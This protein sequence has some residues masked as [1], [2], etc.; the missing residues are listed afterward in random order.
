LE[1]TKHGTLFIDEIGE[2]PL[3]SQVK[4]L[5]LLEDRTYCKLG[6]TEVL[7]FKGRIIMA[8]H[9]NLKKMMKKKLFREDLFYRV[10]ILPLSIPPLRKRKEEL[11]L[12]SNKI[13]QKIGSSKSLTYNALLKLYNY[14]WPGNIREL[15]SVLLRANTMSNSERWIESAD[16]FFY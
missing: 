15:Q 7:H 4:L 16:I 13:L 5:R 11:P 9:R 14:K 12:L 2:L 10:N 8:T 3:F 1:I 6:S